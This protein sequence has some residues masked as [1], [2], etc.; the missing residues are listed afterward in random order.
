MDDIYPTILCW[1]D[2][3][4]ATRMRRLSRATSRCL[5]DN[6]VYRCVC[7]NAFVDG[8]VYRWL[9]IC[10]TYGKLDLLQRFIQT[11]K[12][13]V[14]TVYPWLSFEATCHGHHDITSYLLENGHVRDDVKERVCLLKAKQG[15]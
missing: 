12:V 15:L 7:R 10:A 3:T 14:V 8:T 11:H 4:T 13:R 9:G 6:D 5:T 1:C 2:P